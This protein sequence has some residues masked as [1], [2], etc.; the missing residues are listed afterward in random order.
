MTEDATG[1][2]GDPEASYVE[3]LWATALKPN[4]LGEMHWLSG[5]LS[6]DVHRLEWDSLGDLKTERQQEIQRAYAHEIWHAVQFAMFGWTNRWAVDAWR[7]VAEAYQPFEAG[8]N[9]FS[10][11]RKV[12]TEGA[13]VLSAQ[14][15]RELTR[16]VA[17]LDEVGAYGLTPRAV[18][19][20]HAHAFEIMMSFEIRT[21]GEFLRLLDDAPA[22]AYRVAFDAFNVASQSAH[23]ASWFPSLQQ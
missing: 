9:D 20:S 1:K 23:S 16:V 14:H 6:L 5:A 13:D 4:Q 18:V 12:L 22:R 17:R 3:L 11:V 7:V 10:G 15:K 21:P 2:F 8:P 19:E